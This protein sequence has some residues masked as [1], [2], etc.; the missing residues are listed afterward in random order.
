MTSND[1]A[2]IQYRIVSHHRNAFDC[3]PSLCGQFRVIRSDKI[4]SVKQYSTNRD[5]ITGDLP[6]WLTCASEGSVHGFSDVFSVYR[7]VCTGFMLSMDTR[8]RLLMGNTRLELY[9][10]FGTAYRYSCI[11]P[12]LTHYRLAYSLALKEQTVKLLLLCLWKLIYTR[13]KYP[14]VAYLH[15]RANLQKRKRET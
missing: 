9:K 14:D 7:K 15:Y 10:V 3:V 5:I 4:K 2:K 6:L 11:S 8:R 1:S 13:I 12:A